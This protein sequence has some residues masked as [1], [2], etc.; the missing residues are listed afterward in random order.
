MGVKLMVEVLDRAPE[1]L[2][3]RE[4]YVLVVLAENARDATRICWPGIEDDAM[5]VRRSRLVS[6]TQRYAVI[7]SLVAKGVLE[8]SR[9]G[10]K[11]VRAE[12]RIAELVPSQGPGNQDP[13]SRPEIP[14]T[15]TLNGAQGP[16][17]RDAENRDPERQGP[18]SEVSGSRISTFRVP[19]TGTPSPHTPQSPQ[20]GV[21]GDD[22]PSLSRPAPT[23]AR[24]PSLIPERELKL[25]EAVEIIYRWGRW[26][27]YPDTTH[28][29]AREVHQAFRRQYG[30][31]PVGYLRKMAE[32]D[33]GGFDTLYREVRERHAVEI[34]T[35]IEAL[36]E[37]DPECEH[38]T[39]AGR[40]A[41]PVTGS[42]LCP[43]CRAG[44]PAAGAG[45]ATPEPVAAAVDAYRSAFN[46]SQGTALRS[47]LLV[48][49]TQQATALL[50]R[51]A[52]A[53]QLTDLARRAGVR[54]EGLVE[55]A[56]REEP[57]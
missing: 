33:G 12:Y 5:F 36:Q 34:K 20:G 24:Q 55:A 27:G 45:P 35:Q 16:E 51:G 9:R 38:G 56:T 13:E 49:I 25:P 19:E 46:T 7:Q 52:D 42:L 11:G 37:T 43:L 10:Q 32:P 44:T 1:T 41:H 40:S 18:G 31:K 23:A 21:G 53:Q 17:N 3:P 48:D 28:A 39:R 14:E 4:R 54:G 29:E 22:Q 2:T 8:R 47:M 6:R 50:A 57:M 30:T 15:G 26:N